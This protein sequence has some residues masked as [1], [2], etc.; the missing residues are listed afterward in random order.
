LLISYFFE[1]FMWR[2]QTW[3]GVG[4][5]IVGNVVVLRRA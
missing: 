1:G 3:V 2:P 5:S 4:L